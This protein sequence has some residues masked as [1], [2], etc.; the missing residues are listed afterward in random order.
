MTTPA[1][2]ECN[3]MQTEWETNRMAGQKM[4]KRNN[5]V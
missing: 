1:L 4:G 3:E 2:K 5:K